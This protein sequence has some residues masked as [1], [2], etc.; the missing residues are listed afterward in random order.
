MPAAIVEP[1]PASAAGH[2]NHL[3]AKTLGLDPSLRTS[4]PTQSL[5]FLRGLKGAESGSET[6][7]RPAQAKL[8]LNIVIAGAGLGGLATSIALA[9]R[10]HSVIVLEQA[11]KLDEVHKLTALTTLA[12]LCFF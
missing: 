5:S 7:S 6:S 1:A 3:D 11:P 9:R 2:H 10:G 12:V 8:K 4:Y